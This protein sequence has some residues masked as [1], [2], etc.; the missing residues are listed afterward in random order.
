MSNIVKETLQERLER[1]KIRNE[2][3]RRRHMVSTVP[4]MANVCVIYMDSWR[5]SM[6]V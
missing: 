3:I 2:E 5:A 1:M 4:F 6:S